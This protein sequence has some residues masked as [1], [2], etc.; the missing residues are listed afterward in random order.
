MKIST[1]QVLFFYSKIP[2][3]QRILY[4]G[5]K[6]VVS[7]TTKNKKYEKFS[8]NLLTKTTKRDTITVEAKP[9]LLTKFYISSKLPFRYQ[10]A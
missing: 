5:I 6:K 8:K 10:L 3:F 1:D 2:L 9:Y 4:Q 7:S